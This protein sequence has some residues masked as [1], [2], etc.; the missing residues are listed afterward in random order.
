M[1][2]IIMIAMVA[3]AADMELA[4]RTEPQAEINEVVLQLY[5]TEFVPDKI[6]WPLTCTDGHYRSQTPSIL[7]HEL[8]RVLT[9]LGYGFRGL[10]VG[11][12]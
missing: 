3:G 11:H 7:R 5:A 8:S 6:E 2:A 12:W 1:K 4:D 10:S 9:T